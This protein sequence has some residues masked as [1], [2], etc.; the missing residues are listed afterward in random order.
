MQLAH[1]AP[2]LNKVM[3]KSIKKS[4]AKFGANRL[5]GLGARAGKE[6][7]GKHGARLGKA[8]VRGGINVSSESLEEGA[9]EINFGGC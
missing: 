9:Q 4:L 7:F 3:S 8:L 5:S 6:L 1:V 2:V